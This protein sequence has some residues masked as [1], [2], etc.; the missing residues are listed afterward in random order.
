MLTSNGPGTLNKSL[1]SAKSIC[2]NRWYA[3]LKGKQN[4][5]LKPDFDFF[6]MRLCLQNA[7]HTVK[8][9]S[10]ASE[11]GHASETSSMGYRLL[12]APTV[13]TLMPTPATHTPGLESPPTENPF[14]QPLLSIHLL[15]HEVSYRAH[16]PS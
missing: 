1:G 15:I 7:T 11:E 3:L 13:L 14:T 4:I 12:G 9:Y 10:T 8:N 5:Y 6:G 2:L 16:Q